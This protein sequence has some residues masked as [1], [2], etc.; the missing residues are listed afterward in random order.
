MGCDG[1]DHCMCAT[2][3]S[4]FILSSFSCFLYF[5]LSLFFSTYSSL[6]QP[7]VL[8]EVSVSDSVV[9]E[10]I[11]EAPSPPAIHSGSVALGVAT[12]T[13]PPQ[14]LSDAEV[15]IWKLLEGRSGTD[16][17]KNSAGEGSKPSC[18]G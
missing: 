8:K 1:S 17:G 2:C 11:S 10:N 13:P 12:V 4:F 6:G 9:P 7:F 18:G 5:L 16:K 14:R 3:L 15:P